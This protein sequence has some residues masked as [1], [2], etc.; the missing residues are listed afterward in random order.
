MLLSQV[1]QMLSNPSQLNIPLIQTVIK[2]TVIKLRY[3]S[4]V[5]LKKQCSLLQPVK[6]MQCS[7][8]VQ[9]CRKMSA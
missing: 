5:I 1:F 2:F 6:S 9:A 4:I 8:Y 3:T 7:Q